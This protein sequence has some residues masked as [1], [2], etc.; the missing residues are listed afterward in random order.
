MNKRRT[1]LFAV[2][3]VAITVSVVWAQ[4]SWRGFDSRDRGDR[5]D[6]PMWSN[7][8]GFEQDVFT[9]VRV[10]YSS[11]WGRGRGGGGWRT[12]WPDADLNFSYR[13]QQLTALKVDPEGRTLDLTNPELFHYPFI[14]MA[15]PGRLQL[16]EE[17]VK[18]LRRYLL[19][20]GFMMV[21]DFWG[22]AEY[23]NFY[24][25]I[26][27]V[28]PER[29]PVDLPLEHPIFQCVFP[30][31]EKPQLP[32]MHHVQRYRGTPYESYEREDAE[33]VNY[34]A[35]FDDKGRLMVM[36]CHNTDLGDGWEREGEDEYYFRE[37]AEN[38]AYPMGIN[39]IFYAL[40]H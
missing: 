16:D 8:P 14:Y 22:E 12:D 4:R 30:L 19:N 9:F 37:Y 35:I 26:K 27:R 13:L 23:A 6:I 1:I 11:G 21:D 20:G 3:L 29:E 39:I 24:D 34:R 18:A 28:F 25:E 32:S 10:I 15:E 7:E 38:K 17:E 2:V 36:I 31:K 5:G 33:Q 40:T